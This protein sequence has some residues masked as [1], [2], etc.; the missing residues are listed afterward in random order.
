MSRPS[1]TIRSLFALATLALCLMP[2]CAQLPPGTD[3]RSAPCLQA[4]RIDGRFDPGE[5]DAAAHTSFTMQMNRAGGTAQPR[6]V[7]LWVMNSDTNLY[8]AL[9]IP[10]AERHAS[11]NPVKCDLTI[12]AF[13]QGETLAAGDDRKVLL[14]MMYG[15]KHVVKPGQDADDK[16]QNGKGVMGFRDGMYTIEYGFP[17]NS[18]DGEDLA[19]KPGDRVRFNLVYADSF[20]AQLAGTEV[21]GLFTASADDAKGWG[22]LALADHVGPEKPA[23]DPEWLVKLFPYTDEPDECAR[24]FKRVDATELPV[25]D[26]FG[27][28]VTCEFLYRDFDGKT[29]KAQACLFLPPQ[30]RH[31]PTVRV[32]L[33]CNAGYELDANSAAGLLAKGWAVSTVHANAV[34]PMDR[35]PN[36]DVALLH[37]ARAL[38]CVDDAKVMIQGGSAGGYMTLMLAAESFPLIS[39]T[40]MVPPVNWGYNAAY[41]LHNKA[42]ATAIPPGGKTPTLPVLT[43]VVG[44]AEIGV[45]TMGDDTDA[46]SW[47][48]ASPISQLD[49]ITA[50]VQVVWSTGDMLVPVDQVSAQLLRA[51]KPGIFPEGFTSSITA[52]M[53]RPQT[54]ARLL[55]LLPKSAY[56]TFLVPV[57][58][59]AP[60]QTEGK[61]MTGQAP[62]LELPFSKGKV[63]SIVVVDE[64]PPQPAAGHFCYWFNP[65]YQP[66]LTWA[67][68]RGLAADQLTGAKL[69]RLMMRVEGKEYRPV[70]SHPA[71]APA[72][73]TVVRLDFPAA[74]RRDV[75]QG[76][77][78]FAADGARAQRL[79]ACYAQLPPGL[80]ALGASLGSTPEAIRAALNRALSAL[81]ASA[82]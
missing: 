16:V 21:G 42:L 67:L 78:A 11:L 79:A 12:L 39:A 4:P 10:Q 76:L 1:S 7:E 50:P 13:C 31:D 14:P 15:D 25:G 81:T 65:D 61:A 32:P 46:D 59:G 58:P 38:P 41:F 45:K 24:R 27:G 57:P 66:F 62:A 77:I 64:G 53:K 56:E 48:M 43:V 9:R 55:D 63:W 47:L 51:P 68:G 34:N 26:D 19:A 71:G 3:V 80:K 69:T 74:E 2:C 52:L 37:A 72:P 82:H 44:L 40:P 33:M 49:S 28:R 17:L 8:L 75:L 22:F 70:I 60:S 54:R 23:P 29:A 18:G 35:G 5:W 73:I 36:L 6:Q 30:V 20:A